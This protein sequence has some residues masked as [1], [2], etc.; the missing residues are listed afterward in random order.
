MVLVFFEFLNLHVF[1]IILFLFR[2]LHLCVISYNFYLL[3]LLLSVDA[4]LYF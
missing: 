1:L 2:F 3:T 4:D